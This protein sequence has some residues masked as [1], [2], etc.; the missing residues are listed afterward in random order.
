MDGANAVL[1]NGCGLNWTTILIMLCEVR[2]EIG[3]NLAAFEEL[4]TWLE[5]HPER[6]GDVDRTVRDI[7]EARAVSKE[8]YCQR[9]CT[10]VR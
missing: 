10:A 5:N 6:M 1:S 9:V 4:L 8:C 3:G 2:Q 7:V